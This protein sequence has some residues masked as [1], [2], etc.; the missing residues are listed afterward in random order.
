MLCGGLNRELHW[1]N[2]IN[3]INQETAHQDKR[4]KFTYFVFF[5]VIYQL[6]TIVFQNIP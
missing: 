6:Y 3:Q 4:F 2:C 1:R 5:F